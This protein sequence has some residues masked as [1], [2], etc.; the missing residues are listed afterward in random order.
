[1][2]LDHYISQLLFHYD[3]VIVPN[4][5]GFVANYKPAFIQPIKN[6]F[7]PPSKGISF[8]KNLK[9][10]DGL[11]VNAISKELGITYEMALQKVEIWVTEMNAELKNNRKLILE[12]IG[13]LFF[14]IENRIQFEPS[15]N[16]NYL[17]EA[18][19]LSSFQQFPIQRQSIEE[20]VL[21]Q[22]KEAPIIPITG[23][24]K[25]RKW[26]A[27]AV[28]T[29]PLTFFAIWLPTKYDLSTEFNVASLNPFKSNAEPVYVARETVPVFHSLEKD[30]VVEKI[31]TVDES[32]PF[33]AVSF[34]KDE[35]PIVVKNNET[36]IAEAV[37]THVETA[38][39]QLRFHIIGGCFSEKRNA[40]RLV[41]KLNKAGF[42]AWIIGKR[43][44]LFAVSYNSFATRQEAV[45]ALVFA[46]QHNAKA[47]VLE[48]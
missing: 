8:N 41:K 33:T 19:G 15:S 18:Y 13:V 5:G 38:K 9:N 2:K 23:N 39:I 44:G 47:W 10:N 43:K 17:L 45:D 46:Q 1:M 48:Q 3:C 34:L 28:I 27:A 25:S 11:L 40:Q 24:K 14:D 22:V 26:V 6:T 12:D 30:E 16:V 32:N 7:H 29:I 21:A 42:D 36:S 35:A 37:S 31:A 4:L 20:R